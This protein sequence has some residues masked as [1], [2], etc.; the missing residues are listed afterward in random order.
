MTGPA[1]TLRAGDDDAV[2][3][4]LL[5]KARTGL[6]VALE[7]AGLEAEPGASDLELCACIVTDKRDFLRLGA[8]PGAVCCWPP[9]VVCGWPPTVLR[10]WD[11]GRDFGAD[12]GLRVVPTAGFRG[13]VDR[14]GLLRVLSS[15]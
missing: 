11:S 12:A 7:V 15:S 14:E 6:R 2:L 10:S 13:P 1:R 9:T 4:P 8:G 5:E 3:L